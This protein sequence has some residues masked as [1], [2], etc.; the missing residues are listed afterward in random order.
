MLKEEKT[1]QQGNKHANIR[2]IMKCRNNNTHM[3]TK[4]DWGTNMCTREK[5]FQMKNKHN[6]IEIPWSKNDDTLKN[7]TGN[8]L[9]L[10]GPY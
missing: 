2:I 8:R 1:C 4:F 3:V 6:D 9:T 7:N 10:P 5:N